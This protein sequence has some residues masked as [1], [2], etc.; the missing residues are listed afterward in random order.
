MMVF[1]EKKYSSEK[2][3][4][5]ALDYLESLFSME[6]NPLAK[7][8][9]DVYNLDF[10]REF[11]KRLGDPQKSYPVIHIAGT[12]GKGSTAIL[13]N[14]ILNSFGLKTGLYMSPHICT[15]RE[16]IKLNGKLIPEK[17]FAEMIF[18]LRDSVAGREIGIRTYFELLTAAA[19]MYFKKK[20][21]DVAILEA[22][23]GGRL[24]ATNIADSDIAV[25]TKIAMDHQKAL[26]NTL[27]KIL[28]EK[29]G[30]I[31]D[32]SSVIIQ[33]TNKRLMNLS[34]EYAWKNN[35]RKILDDSEVANN[36]CFSIDKNDCIKIENLPNCDISFDIEMRIRGLYQG[37]NLATAIIACTEFLQ[38]Q[39]LKIDNINEKII[40]ASSEAEIIG[41]VQKISDN[42]NI[43][44]DGGHNK[45]AVEGSLKYFEKAIEDDRRLILIYAGMYDKDIPGIMEIFDRYSH[46][47]D[48]IIFTELENP[49]AAKIDELKST[50]SKLEIDKKYFENSMDAYSFVEKS[51]KEGSVFLVIGSLYLAADYL[52]KCG[53]CEKLF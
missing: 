41:R 27:E 49:R 4:I 15:I 38:R 53:F 37:N 6:R 8:S 51:T 45:N 11:L 16:R 47:I 40:K 26:G 52:D 43:F 50:S 29:L 9:S 24:D 30:I 10:M 25:I 23:L 18:L 13:I 7:R 20:N 32:D 48:R 14:S 3:F 5:E 42:P 34:Y 22:G 17:D 12:N 46:L 19:M 21:V 28:Y 31:K 44:I 1:P 36:S 35:A 2:K 33:A 39:N